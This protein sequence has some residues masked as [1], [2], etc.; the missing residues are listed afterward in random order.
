MHATD[1]VNGIV[2]LNT[3]DS[4]IPDH[5]SPDTSC[6]DAHFGRNLFNWFSLTWNANWLSV[7]VFMR[8]NC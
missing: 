1:K 4:N 2:V 8:L 6:P 7:F 5:Y 3:N